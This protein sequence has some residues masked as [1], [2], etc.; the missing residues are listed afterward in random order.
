MAPWIGF[1]VFFATCLELVFGHGRLIEPPS[2][3]SMWKYGFP[4]PENYDDNALYCGGKAHQWDVLGGLCGLCGDAF[5][6]P[7][8]NEAGGKYANGIITRTYQ[9]GA[10]INV[11]IDMS[12]NHKGWMEFKI[13]PN[14]NPYKPI[15][16]KC[17]NAHPLNVISGPDG[18]TRP[19]HRFEIMQEWSNIQLLVQLPRN[20]RCS[21]CVLQW[22]YHSGNSWGQDAD[23]TEC[24][25]CGG[26]EEFYGCSDVAIGAKPI[27]P[28]PIEKRGGPGKTYP[29][30]KKL[31][32]LP[33]PSVQVASPVNAPE[34]PPSR[35]QSALV[36]PPPYLGDVIRNAQRKANQERRN[37]MSEM[38]RKIGDNIR[39]Q[40]MPFAKPKLPN[41]PISKPKLPQALLGNHQANGH[42]GQRVNPAP[43]SQKLPQMMDRKRITPLRKTV[44]P[45]QKIVSRRRNQFNRGK[46]Q[47]G[48]SPKPDIAQRLGNMKNYENYVDNRQ[49]Q[50]PEEEVFDY[51]FEYDHEWIEEMSSSDNALRRKYE[52]KIKISKKTQI[53][54]VPDFHQLN[55]NLTTR[56]N[57]NRGKSLKLYGDLEMS[58]GIS[59]FYST[60]LA[61]IVLFLTLIL[62]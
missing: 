43:S 61:I 51:D 40:G 17:L 57:V 4:N 60:K 2:R 55:K 62:C 20:L 8:E 1:T 12:A 59:T 14:N 9:P 54:D 5:E 44:L 52:D 37:D 16:Q 22:K 26:Q 53:I 39:P 23:G 34:P 42:R 56:N 29:I 24:I 31:R 19:G 13:C 6:G 18:R 49:I 10:R 35:Q 30:P 15:T 33:Q 27:E 47:I 25:G 28:I 58:S 32:T 11:T 41:A 48:L 21:Q 7:R 36:K 38:K 50:S 45:Q 3:S 46:E